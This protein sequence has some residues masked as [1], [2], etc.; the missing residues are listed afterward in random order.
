[1]EYRAVL[2]NNFTTHVAATHAY[3]HE[4]ITYLY[5]I[6]IIM[7]SCVHMLFVSHEYNLLHE[8]THQC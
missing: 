4:I 2:C 1:M 8:N 3:T 6:G 5:V 7:I